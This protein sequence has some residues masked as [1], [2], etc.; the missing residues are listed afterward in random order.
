MSLS[1]RIHGR[2]PDPRVVARPIEGPR[3]RLPS[4]V[5]R[6]Q[7]GALYGYDRHGLPVGGKSM[8]GRGS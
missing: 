3:Q 8:D 7:G 2:H 4:W 5:Q 6:A 1:E